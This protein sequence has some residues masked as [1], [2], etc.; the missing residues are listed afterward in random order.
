VGAIRKKEVMKFLWKNFYGIVL[1][2]AIGLLAVFV[3]S[4]LPVGAV[5]V[6]IILGIIVGNTIKLKDVFKG[7]ITFCEK[8]VLSL[9][10][11][12]MGINLNF[13]I[14]QK[15]G[16]KSIVLVVCAMLVTILTALLLGKIFKLNKTFAILLGIGN[17]VCGSSAIAATEKVI[18]AKEEEVG[19]SIAIVN[20]YGALGIFII[21]F[22]AKVICNF[23]YFNSGILAGNTL[24]AV[25]QVVAAGEFIGGVAKEIA[26]IVKMTRIL[27]LLPIVFILI[28]CFKQNN[29]SKDNIKKPKIPLFIIGFV[30]FSLLPTFGLV[31]AEQVKI[32]GKISS[33]LLIVAMSGIGLKI[34]FRSI[35]NNGRLALLI[36]GFIFLVQIVFSSV[37]I[38][39]FY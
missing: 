33:Y 20:F 16:F 29:S 17:G 1:C 8:H 11:A 36:G 21:P 15:L 6:A 19:L 26:T 32:I 2:V 9:A 27:M 35:L 10:I 23:D 5:V 28:F 25:G 13:M 18:G 7:G 38:W 14:L 3:G 4:Y 34:T 22:V 31:S 30:F 39:L 24:Q 12:M 37:A